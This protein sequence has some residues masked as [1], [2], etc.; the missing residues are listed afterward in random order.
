MV[1]VVLL[2]TGLDESNFNDAK[3]GISNAISSVY[4]VHVSNITLLL[5]IGADGM[6]LQQDGFDFN[7]TAEIHTD[8]NQAAINLANAIISI[9]SDVRFM[10]CS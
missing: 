3:S 9:V 10:L 4:S 5:N 7:V 2:M 8:S 1:E 6:G